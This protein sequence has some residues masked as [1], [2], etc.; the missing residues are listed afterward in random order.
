M[1][2]SDLLRYQLYECNA[3]TIPI[4]KEMAYLKDYIHLQQKR[5]DEN[6]KVEFRC[7]SSV[8]NFHIVPL[9]LVPFVENAFKHI[10]HFPERPNTIRINADR[11]ANTFIFKVVNSSENGH[12]AQ[13]INPG[14]IGLKNVKR[15][16][17]LLYDGKHTLTISEQQ[18]VF[19][20][21]LSITV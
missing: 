11:M 4:E 7:T 13:E 8:K 10:S 21:D 18:N 6:Y 1:Q 20:I 9:L 19:S 17:D 16:L 14:G 5:K 15:R 12:T 2:F 3:E